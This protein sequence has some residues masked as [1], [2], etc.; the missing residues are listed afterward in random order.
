[1]AE[2]LTNPGFEAT[3]VLEGVKRWRVGERIAALPISVSLG[4][5]VAISA[6][7]HFV[8]A[9]LVPAPWIF[10]DELRY[11][12]L[13][14]SF[15]S[16]GHFAIRGVPGSGLG[17]LYPILISPA[18]ALFTDVPNAYVAAKAINAVAISLGAVPAY[19]L[20]RRLLPRSWS[21]VVAGLAILLPSTVYAGTIM[22]ENVFY[23]LFVGASL[24]IVLALE[25][26]TVAHQLGALG[27]IGLAFLTR[28][29][30]I[31]L[32]PAFL[33]AIA[34]VCITDAWG[35]QSRLRTVRR[36]LRRFLATWTALAAAFVAVVCLEALRGRSVLS[37]FGEAQGRFQQNY[38]LGTVAKWFLYHLAELDLYVGVL[39]FAAF[40]ILIA[41]ARSRQDR[42]L[43]VF[44]LASLSIVSWFLLIVAFYTSS[45]TRYDPHAVSHI[46]DR[47]TFYVVPLLLVA[48]L[49]WLTTRLPGSPR[50]AAAA[51]IGAG[52]LIFVLPLG[53]LIHNNSVPD[54]LAF[55]PWVVTNANGM[56][57]A[58]PHVEL[59]AAVV[60][61]ALALLFYRLRPPL[62]PRLSVLLVALYLGTMLIVAERWYFAEGSVAVAAGPDK[63]WIDHAIGP[64]AN[65][66]AIWSGHAGSYLIMENELFNRSVGDV[67]YLEQPTWAGLPEQKLDIRPSSGEIVDQNGEPFRARYV[68]ADPWIVLQAPVEA[69][70][71]KTGM[72][73]Y[74]LGGH[75]ARIGAF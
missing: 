36:G 50:A 66:A 9:L 18:W 12:E 70:D 65:A 55:L 40:L 20:A 68:L 4:G 53:D 56:I 31:A 3:P 41:H 72:R 27:L 33:T 23:P 60:T 43:R 67:Y 47:Y 35:E 48:L 6:V 57:V 45:L 21:L 2:T 28:S 42:P 58:R 26:P 25:R 37:V 54:T 5:L 59:L 8:L 49:A 17:P 14:K 38:D 52:G 34:A 46:E 19:L 29:Q 71:P 64:N 39:P 22:T 30:A 75:V 73:L 62:F 13:A 16:T 24:M 74:R 63:A 10:A 61:L 51:A 15:A 32:V 7:L 44:A 11:S 69:R 1:M